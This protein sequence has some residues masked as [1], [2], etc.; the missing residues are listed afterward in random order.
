MPFVTDNSGDLVY[1]PMAGRDLESIRR[2]LGLRKIEFG[3]LLGMTGENRNIYTT[4]MRYEAGRRDISPTVERLALMLIWFKRERGY[5]PDLD[6]GDMAA[7]HAAR[8]VANG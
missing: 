6:R 2:E 4:I 8:E 5:I 7:P 3:Q 1:R